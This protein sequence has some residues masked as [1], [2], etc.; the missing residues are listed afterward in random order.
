M[1]SEYRWSAFLGGPPAASTNG[2]KATQA[3]QEV[4]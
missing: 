2:Q 4:R 3:S 1:V